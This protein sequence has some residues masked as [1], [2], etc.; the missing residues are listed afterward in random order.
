MLSKKKNIYIYIYIYWIL[1][2]FHISWLKNFVYVFNKHR[3]EFKTGD[4]TLAAKLF[5]TLTDIQMGRVEDKKG[6][7]VELTDATTPGLKL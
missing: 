2:C 3:T 4:K 1:F 7:T 5:A 6:W